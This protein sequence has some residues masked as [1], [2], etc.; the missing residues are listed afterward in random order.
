MNTLQKYVF[1]RQSAS[2]MKSFP[3]VGCAAGE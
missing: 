2:Q 3:D 1:I